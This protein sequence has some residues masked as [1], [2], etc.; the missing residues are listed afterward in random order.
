[1]YSMNAGVCVCVWR[2]KFSHKIEITENNNI[3]SIRRT[4]QRE[5]KKMRT[6]IVIADHH[7][8]HK[9]REIINL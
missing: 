7:G 8:G 5:R 9:Q 2:L 4:Y 1:M 3:A 6:I